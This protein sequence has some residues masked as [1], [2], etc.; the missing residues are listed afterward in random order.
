MWDP[1]L[2]A[3]VATPVILT[4]VLTKKIKGNLDHLYGL[5]ASSGSPPNGSFEIDSDG[6]GIPNNCAVSLYPGGSF[7]MDAGNPEHGAF[8]ARFTHPGG[9]GN[10]GG[11]LDFDYQ[12]VDELTGYVSGV[13]LRT[14]APGMNILVQVLWYTAAKVFMSSNDLYTSTSN[15]TSFARAYALIAPLANARYARIRLVGG[16]LDTDV[17]GSVHVVPAVDAFVREVAATDDEWVGDPVAYP[18]ED[19]ER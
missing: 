4:Q 11:Y 9:A 14:D 2:D 19:F 13:T 3:E 7:A 12:E 18:G 17:A 6:D 5:A 16:Y 1:I 10:G 15:P 8:S